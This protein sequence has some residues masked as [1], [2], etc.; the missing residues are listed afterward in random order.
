MARHLRLFAR[1]AAQDRA[2]TLGYFHDWSESGERIAGIS[3]S[4]IDAAADLVPRGYVSLKAAAFHY[5]PVLV[6]A[7]V[8]RA[9]ERGV[10]AHFDSHEH[11]TADAT[12]AC[13][14]QAA[15]TGVAVGL[16]LPGRWRRSPADVDLACQLGARVRVVKGEWADPGE[17]R[18]DKRRGFLGVI[19]RLAGRATEVAVATHD[20]WLAR[21]ALGRLQAAGSR[22]E[23]ELLNGLPRRALLAVAREFSVPVRVYIPFGISWRPYALGKA[24]ENPRILWWVLRDTVVG[25]AGRI[26]ALSAR[27]G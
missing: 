4:I 15:A 18:M 20:P 17:P 7:I 11:A 10:L 13:V 3:R 22:C 1:L 16:T 25:L 23:L 2:C 26:R 12:M 21:E 14:R 19:D 6:A 5:D 24:A 8:A 27:S 9:G